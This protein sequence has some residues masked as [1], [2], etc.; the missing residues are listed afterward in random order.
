ME[1]VL[2]T[3]MMTLERNVLATLIVQKTSTV[4]TVII[5][6]EFNYVHQREREKLVARKTRTTMTV[7]RSINVLKCHSDLI[8]VLELIA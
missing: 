3:V 7:L 6:Q 2:P 8:N 4:H 1:S 5:G